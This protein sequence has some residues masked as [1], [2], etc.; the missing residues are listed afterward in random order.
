MLE[1]FLRGVGVVP[2]GTRG[3]GRGPGVGA[4]LGSLASYEATVGAFDL[5]FRVLV[6]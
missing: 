3:P 5:R 4:C 2:S 6:D 1:Y